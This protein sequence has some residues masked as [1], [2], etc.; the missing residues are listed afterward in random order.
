MHPSIIHTY[1]TVITII[2]KLFSNTLFLSLS[3]CRFCCRWNWWNFTSFCCFLYRTQFFF[4]LFKKNINKPAT[5]VWYD[6]CVFANKTHERID[7]MW[8]VDDNVE[9]KSF[10]DDYRIEQNT[11]DTHHSKHSNSMNRAP[12]SGVR[13]QGLLYE[14]A[15][16]IQHQLIWFA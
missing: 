7:K 12:V 14:P 4:F 2:A 6:A 8:F 3:F 9:R 16:A 15:T 10:Y 13:V 1:I 5:I 11:T